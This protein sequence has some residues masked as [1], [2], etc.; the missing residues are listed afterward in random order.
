MNAR[1]AGR[2]GTTPE[3][4]PEA[5]QQTGEIKRNAKGDDYFDPGGMR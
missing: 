2:P 5:E 1:H 4:D 3:P